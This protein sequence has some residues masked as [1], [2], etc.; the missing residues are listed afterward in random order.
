MKAVIYLD[1][2]DTNDPVPA[3]HFGPHPDKGQ[4]I[5]DLVIDNKLVGRKVVATKQLILIGEL[6]K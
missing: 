4:I 3:L 1:T 2:L 5:L 6:F